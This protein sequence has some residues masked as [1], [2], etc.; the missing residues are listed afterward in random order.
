MVSTIDNLM[1]EFEAENMILDED[2]NSNPLYE[3]ICKLCVYDKQSRCLMY[4]NKV[5]M[6]CIVCVYTK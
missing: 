6:M 1:I 5:L 4:A 2:I 3:C